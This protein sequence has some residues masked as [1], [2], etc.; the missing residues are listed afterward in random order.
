MMTE[1]YEMVAKTFQ[2]LEGVLAEELKALNAQDVEVGRRVVTFKGDKE[3]MY[4]AN[5]CCR[6]ALRILK[7]IYKFRASDADELYE[8][9]MKFDWD[10]VLSPSQ[11]FSIDSTV[12]SEDFRH[13]KFVTYRVKD[14]IA[15]FFNDKYNKRPSI[16]LTNADVMFDVHISG[17]EFTLSLDSSGESLHKRGYRVAQTEAPINEVLAAGII[18]LSGW[19]GKSNF[20]DPMCGSGTFLIEAALI[21]ANINPGVFRNS[22]AFERWPDFDQ[23]LFDSIYNDDSKEC[24]FEYKIYGSD[25]S[26]K[27]VAIAERNIKSASVGKYIDLQVKSIQSIEEAPE[28]GGIVVTNPPYGERISV[29]DMEALYAS[30]GERFKKVFKG[31]NAWV[32]GYQEELFDKIGLKPS[33][34]FPLLN[35]ALECELRQYVIFDGTYS[36]FRKDGNSVKNE[37][38]SSE[39]KPK[40]IKKKFEET[41]LDG[42]KPK[43]ER[44]EGDRDRKFGDRDNKFGNR[45]RKFGDRDR[46]FG[47][48]DRK[49]GDRDRKFGDR[50]RKFGDKDRKFGDSERK[51]GDRDRKFGDRHRPEGAPKNALEERYRKP[52]ET[53]RR[54]DEERENRPKERL[55]GEEAMKKFRFHGPKLSAENEVPIIRG[56]RNGWK[57]KDID[58]STKGNDDSNK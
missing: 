21:A 41:K 56:R 57:R 17:N 9:V 22:F 16:R 28:G 53:R 39:A 43:R 32:I 10:K 38:F 52:Y 19:D 20:V 11:T 35:G 23:E 45:D 47:D 3:T 12:F 58:D 24:D 34:K 13:S 54:E 51:F 44:R 1:N 37:E 18:K 6:T 42:D 5:F 55:H 50:D 48:K 4:R 36:D 30:I 26:P 2:G 25:I 14:A 29:E 27:A 31:Y 46:K 33:L 8:A 7:P 49:F 15:D 40:Y